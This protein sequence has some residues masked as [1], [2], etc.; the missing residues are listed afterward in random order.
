MNEKYSD[1]FEQII[2]K[3]AFCRYPMRH[4][5]NCW[6]WR[7]VAAEWV[8]ELAADEAYLDTFVLVFQVWVEGVF[9][10]SE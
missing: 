10:E 5:W 2:L 7:L 3:L 9:L 6:W 4:S 8:F 1:P